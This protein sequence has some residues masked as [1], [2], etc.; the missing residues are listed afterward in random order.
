M[1]RSSA[2]FWFFNARRIAALLLSIWISGAVCVAACWTA[3]ACHLFS[4][5]NKAA[6]DCCRRADKIRQKQPATNVLIEARNVQTTC[7]L[8]TAFESSLAQKFVQIHAP[9]LSAVTSAAKNFDFRF[10]AK[11]MAAQTASYQSPPQD[12]GSAYLHNRVFRI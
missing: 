10:F 4:P 2:K 3:D 8:P 5:N 7:C 9:D 6:H 1:K 11:Q 12:R